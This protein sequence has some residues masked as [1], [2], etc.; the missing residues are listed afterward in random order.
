MPLGELRQLAPA[1]IRKWAAPSGAQPGMPLGELRQLAPAP[2]RKEFLYREEFL[3]PSHQP[4]DA[5][6]VA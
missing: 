4:V 3:Y 6:R 2:I 1:P 5:R